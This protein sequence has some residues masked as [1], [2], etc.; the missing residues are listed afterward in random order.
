MNKKEIQWK[1]YKFYNDN[2]PYKL[3]KT[4]IDNMKTV[5][6]FKN[7]LSTQFGIS[8]DYIDILI[9]D[10]EIKNSE[11]IQILTTKVVKVKTN[12]QK[13]HLKYMALAY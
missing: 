3:F 12:P 13:Q 6:D 7:Y 5:E 10:K 9:D 2:E 8:T 4:S 1:N 11:K